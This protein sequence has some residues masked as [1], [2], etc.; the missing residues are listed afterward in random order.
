LDN[1]FII[2]LSAIVIAISSLAVSIWQGFVS[3]RHN[4]LSVTP[5]LAID[6][7]FTSDACLNGIYIKNTGLGPAIIKSFCIS[8]DDEKIEFEDYK[9]WEMA[10][11]KCDF[12]PN[13]NLSIFVVTIDTI[14]CRNDNYCLLGIDAHKESIENRTIFYNNVKRFNFMIQYES[15]YKDKY[16]LNESGKQLPRLSL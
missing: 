8:I 7:K 1:E 9:L 5:L 16:T 12:P 15:I 4:R 13:F 2:S 14:I 3:R 11:K 10:I 6:F